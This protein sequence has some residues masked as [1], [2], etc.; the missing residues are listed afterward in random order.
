MSDLHLTQTKPC[1][2]CGASERYADGSCKA[3][4]KAR[5]AAWRKKNPERI[6]ANDAA[7]Y[8]ANRETKDAK[9][10]AYRAENPEKRRLISLAW[11]SAN[12]EIDRAAAKRWAKNNKAA[13]STHEYKRRA[14]ERTS[15]V[16]LSKGLVPKLLRLQKGK[17][18]CCRTS[19]A[20]GLHIDHVIPVALGGRHEDSNIQLLCPTCNC[21]KGKK[22]PVE[23]MRTRGFLL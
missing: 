15:G 3:C 21:S 8:A 9:V 19:L 5:S 20:G 23:F 12:R 10:H 2:K 22:H 16:R 17:C 14:L 7:W 6:K 11:R 13:R 18:A 4:K 1:V